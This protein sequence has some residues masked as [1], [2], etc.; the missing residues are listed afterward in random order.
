MSDDV[1]DHN[2]DEIIEFTPEP[3]AKIEEIAP[4][5][6]K[7]TK[8]LEMDAE[9]HFP[10]FTLNVP[11]AATA[12]DIV[13]AYYSVAIEYLPEVRPGFKPPDRGPKLH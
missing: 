7:M 1:F 9:I 13:K 6:A 10:N 5:I 12:M 11:Q 3:G 2:R 4:V 8:K